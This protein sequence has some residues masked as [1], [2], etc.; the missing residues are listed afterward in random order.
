M[1]VQ[2]GLVISTAAKS[3]G[4]ESVCL[5]VKRFDG[6]SDFDLFRLISNLLDNAIAATSKCLAENKH[7]YLKITDDE[8][9]FDIN[10]KNSIEESVLEK[11]PQ[12]F[13][14]KRTRDELG[15]GIRIIREIAEKYNGKCD[16][17]EEE[18]LF[19]CNVIL[20]KCSS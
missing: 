20:T 14:T 10:I 19:C 15:C 2:K 5:S 9:S 13:S 4:I 17:Y 7:I 16:F 12:L 6:V 3:C 8:Y 18:N 1:R 11:N